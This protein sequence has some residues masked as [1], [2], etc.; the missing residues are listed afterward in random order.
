MAIRKVIRM[1]HPTLR[2]I[3]QDV[4][5]EE[6]KSKEMKDLIADM[7]ET[8]KDYDGIGLAAPQ[9]NIS[10]QIAIIEVPDDS[11]RYPDSEGSQLFVMFN[12]KITPLTEELQ[13]FWE[14]CLSVPDLRGF[15]ERPKKIKVD[16]TNFE[17]ERVSMEVE[18]FLATVFQHELDHLQGEL[19]IDKIKSSKLLSFC[20]EFDE[21]YSEED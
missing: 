4:E 21:F 12:P 3:A 19:Y 18:G 9:I 13:G 8:M 5:L 14:G 20:Q 10:K 17:G 11:S 6:I 2:Q 16:Y 1:G 15:V 7:I